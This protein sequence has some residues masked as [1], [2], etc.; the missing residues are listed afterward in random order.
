MAS[1]Q[2]VLYVV[3]EPFI[4]CF[5]ESLVV[6]GAPSALY[7]GPKHGPGRWAHTHLGFVNCFVIDCG[8]CRL[9]LIVGCWRFICWVLICMCVLHMAFSFPACSQGLVVYYARS[10]CLDLPSA[11]LRFA[12]MP[13]L[14][15]SLVCLSP[16]GVCRLSSKIVLDC[17]WPTKHNLDTKFENP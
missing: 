5:L 7:S 2:R 9:S 1:S 6:L 3:L 14:E 16:C 10:H 17:H 8:L 15:L 4:L 11:V 12:N 13:V